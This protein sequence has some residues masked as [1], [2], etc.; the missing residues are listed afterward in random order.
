[1]QYH[2]RLLPFQAIWIPEACR[3]TLDFLYTRTLADSQKLEP[4]RLTSA[5][6]SL[7][8]ADPSQRAISAELQAVLHTLPQC[9]FPGGAA[10]SVTS[11]GPRHLSAQ[12]LQSTHPLTF[13]AAGAFIEANLIRSSEAACIH[14]TKKRKGSSSRY[15]SRA[16]SSK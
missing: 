10:E 6:H 1:M 14:F 7:I 8:P 13:D 4:S 3:T 9:L 12:R 2:R 16:R 11:L 5:K 15:S